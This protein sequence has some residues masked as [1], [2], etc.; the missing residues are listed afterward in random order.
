MSS[1]L[2]NIYKYKMV[3]SQIFCVFT[4]VDQIVANNIGNIN[5]CFIVPADL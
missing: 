4:P 2:E 5:D 1:G 3:I